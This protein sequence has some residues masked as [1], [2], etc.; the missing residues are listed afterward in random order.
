MLLL[1]CCRWSRASKLLTWISF[2]RRLVAQ[3]L[4]GL[5]CGVCLVVGKEIDHSP[6]GFSE[7]LWLGHY[8]PWWHFLH[9]RFSVSQGVTPR[10]GLVDG[11]EAISSW[12]S[13]WS[14]WSWCCTQHR[15]FPVKPGCVLWRFLNFYGHLKRNAILIFWSP[16]CFVMTLSV[17]QIF[18]RISWFCCRWKILWSYFMSTW[19]V[20]QGLWA[21][22]A[23]VW[24]WVLAINSIIWATCIPGV[25]NV[26]AG[27][28]NR[29][30]GPSHEWSFNSRY[31]LPIFEMW[32]TPEVDLFATQHDA[33][34]ERFCSR[35]GLG[36]GSLSNTFQ[37]S[38]V[39]VLFY[40]FLLFPLLARVLKKANQQGSQLML[41]T[42]F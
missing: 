22:A 25:L 4:L 15:C 32:G 26:W 27:R 3:G 5:L 6:N 29:L 24:N 16:E 14:S 19:K 18:W 11:S 13:L 9:H 41:V 36:K 30:R 33:K 34:A 20:A 42:P 38:C 21:E 12:G 7:Q 39:G 31:L 17:S 1:H 37:I 2:A 28:L 10:A 8:C 40:T 35:G 23:A